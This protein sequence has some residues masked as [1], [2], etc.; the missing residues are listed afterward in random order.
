MV[1][2]MPHALHLCD[3]IHSSKCPCDTF[4]VTAILQMQKPRLGQ[5]QELPHK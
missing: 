4:T 3:F 5:I 1:Q 2:V